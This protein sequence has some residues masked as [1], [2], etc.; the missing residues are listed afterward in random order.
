MDVALLGLLVLVHVFLCC[1]RI[2]LIFL[3]VPSNSS[4]F[5]TPPTLCCPPN[6]YIPGVTYELTTI[7]HDYVGFLFIVNLLINAS[8]G[9]VGLVVSVKDGGMG[10]N[11]VEGNILIGNSSFCSLVT[12]GLVGYFL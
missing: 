12:L 10:R 9:I 6:I 3:L 5:F 7:P 4:S 1:F 2:F 8:V 11:I